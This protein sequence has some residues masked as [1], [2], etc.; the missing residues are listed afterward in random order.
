VGLQLEI[1]G[2]LFY[3]YKEMIVNSSLGDLKTPQ[4]TPRFKKL[5]LADLPRCHLHLDLF[6]KIAQWKEH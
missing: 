2:A 4:V 1:T 3:F 6:L 5:K